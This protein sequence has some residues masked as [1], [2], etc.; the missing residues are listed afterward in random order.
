MPPLYSSKSMLTY[1]ALAKHRELQNKIKRYGYGKVMCR[2]K[3][4]VDREGE[5]GQEW[6][7]IK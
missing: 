7:E 5:G 2:G 1:M 4:R 3:G 6:E